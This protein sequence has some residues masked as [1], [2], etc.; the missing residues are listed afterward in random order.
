MNPLKIHGF[1]HIWSTREKL[2]W[3]ERRKLA[4]QASS[5]QKD[6]SGFFSSATMLQVWSLH[7]VERDKAVCI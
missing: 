2:L 4:W 6:L 5:T 1:V 7:T 3:K